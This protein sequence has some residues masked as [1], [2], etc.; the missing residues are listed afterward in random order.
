[1]VVVVQL[2]GDL[3]YENFAILWY[4][5]CREIHCNIRGAFT[6][7]KE[8]RYEVLVHVLQW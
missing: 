4:S 1:M 6:Q 7:M 5:V 3:N 2:G 8:H